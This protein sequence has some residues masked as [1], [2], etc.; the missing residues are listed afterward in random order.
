MFLLVNAGPILA[1]CAS[2]I[3]K[4][5]LQW[6]FICLEIQTRCIFC[7]TAADDDLIFAFWF[8][9]AKSFLVRAWKLSPAKQSSLGLGSLKGANRS[10]G[11]R[12]ERR[13]VAPWLPFCRGV[14]SEGESKSRKTGLKNQSRN[15]LR[16]IVS[17]FL[18]LVN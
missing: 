15:V 17:S 8:E 1:L 18:T 6:S 16:P 11:P 14:L 4:K 12:G 10:R 7:E 3:R 9:I 2:L 13:R 5:S